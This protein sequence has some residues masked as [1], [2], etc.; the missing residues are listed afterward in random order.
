MECDVICRNNGD[1]S[2]FIAEFQT[3]AGESSTDPVDAKARIAELKV[4]NMRF[5]VAV[6][7]CCRKCGRRW[8]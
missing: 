1:F 3:E 6:H 4:G 5:I 7:W 2:R 8:W